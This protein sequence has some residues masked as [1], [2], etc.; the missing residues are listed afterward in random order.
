MGNHARRVFSSTTDI[1]QKETELRA[2]IRW[3][4]V[5]PTS[6]PP[7]TPPKRLRYRFLA[8][9]T[10]EQ[11]ASNASMVF[12]SEQSGRPL[13]PLMCSIAKRRPVRALALAK[14]YLLLLLDHEFQGRKSRPLVRAVT[15]GLLLRPSTRAPMIC[16][17]LEFKNGRHFCCD[18]GLAHVISSLASTWPLYFLLIVTTLPRRIKCVD[19]QQAAHYGQVFHEHYHLNLFFHSLICPEVMKDE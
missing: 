9:E 16:P 14:G 18:F 8:H 12:P 17:G 4:V 6:P 7:D 15:E 13:Q 2:S 5:A 19:K 1:K 3:G 11:G 10:S